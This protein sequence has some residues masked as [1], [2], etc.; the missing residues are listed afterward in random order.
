MSQ[1]AAPGPSGGWLWGRWSAIGLAVAVVTG[2]LDQAHKWW[3]LLGYGMREGERVYVLPFLDI[4]YLRNKG[5]SY[6]MLEMDS[7]RG[8]YLL[9]GFAVLVTIFMWIW[10]ARAGTGRLMAWS[11]GLVMGGAIGNAIDRVLVGGV[12]DY[13]SLH[14][15]GFYWYIFNIADVAIVAGVVG[16]LYDSFVPS[17]NTAQNGG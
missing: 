6:S 17:R 5:V 10:L 13:V 11:L 12:I 7:Q 2:V 1:P 15:F 9:S 4:L 8:Q 14:A 16:L 3:M